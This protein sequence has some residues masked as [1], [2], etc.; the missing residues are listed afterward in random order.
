[1]SISNAFR[2]ILCL[3]LATAMSACSIL[4]KERVVATEG[5]NVRGLVL[6]GTRGQVISYRGI[7]YAAPPVDALR[8]RP[9]QPPEPWKGVLDATQYRKMCPQR[10]P[11]SAANANIPESGMSEDC[12][13][14]N[15]T[16]AADDPDEKRPV[17][18]WF[19]GGGLTSG[20]GNKETYN[21]APLPQKGV[22]LVS[23]THRLGPIGYMAHPE[24]SAESPHDASGN[25]GSLD[26]IAA[27]E[28]VQRNIAAFGGDPDNVTIFGVSGGGQ[29]VLF[30]LASPLA[31]GLFDRAVVMSGGIGGT[32]LEETEKL[33]VR[34]ANA[35]GVEND[36]DVLDALRA[37]S[38]QEI[39]E[40]AND[41]DTGYRS[42]FSIDGWSLH[43]VAATNDVPTIVGFMGA[44]KAPVRSP[45]FIARA[46]TPATRTL[47]KHY[48]YVFTHIP[49]EWGSRG[50]LAYHGGDVSYAFGVPEAI[51]DH[52]G[53][54]FRPGP[55]VDLPRDPGLDYR[56]EWVA[57]A[58]TDMF[59]Q[60]AKT[61]DPNLN[62]TQFE[63]LGKSW[64]WPQ[65][66]ERDLYLDIGIEP[67]VRK[68]W[69]RAGTDQQRPRYESP[70][71]T[72]A[73][74][75]KIVETTAGKV[76]GTV[77]ND[78]GVAIKRFKGIPYAAPP[79]GELRWKAP[80]GV[81]PWTGVRETTEWTDRC[82]Q[83]TSSMMGAGGMGFSEDCLYLN[84]VTPAGSVADN[85]PVMV[86]FHGGG[87]TSG[88]GNSDVYN[89][90]ALPR[91]GVVIVTVN[92]R[93][94]P[95]GYMA[96]P[97]LTAES[98]HQSSGNYGTLDL[99]ASLEWVQENIRAFGGN[100][101]NVLI[102]GESGGGT[103][104][105]SLLS[106]PLAEGLFHRAIIESGSA[107]SLP[108]R[109]TTL[110]E[111]EAAGKRLVAKLGLD[112][113]DDLLAALRAMKWEKIVAAA[114]DR[115][116]RF[117]AN[118]TV[119]GWILPV[120]VN[121]TLRQGRQHDVPLIVG[122]NQGEQR[123]L[124][125]DVPLVA[126]LWSKNVSSNAYV[127]NFSHV[128]TGWREDGCVAFHGLELPYV[129]G[130]IPD[131]LKVPTV[132]FLA[133]RTGCKDPDPG[134]DERDHV[135]ADNTMKMW[136]AFARTGDPGVEGLVTWPPYTKEDGS[137][138]DISYELA[139][140]RGIEDAYVAPPA[141]R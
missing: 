58:M 121:E 34:L 12:L 2:V 37:K 116:A 5:G 120:S 135:V 85:L 132:L 52:Y 38:W 117:S 94:G 77:V 45:A 99:I 44:E 87:L 39:I 124:Q 100:P 51:E 46:I 115:D 80:A 42:L 92:S 25:Y 72:P 111:A 103:K 50:A 69:V 91:K 17:M 43:G 56:D 107:S 1:M 49:Y 109:T 4:N 96:H 130:A 41:P 136:A 76:S 47:S 102:F 62:K 64:N 71:M 16:T 10:F 108:E 31:E 106:S 113:E 129:F 126:S 19:H 7:P 48:A 97:A 75:G 78:T 104:T 22:V 68:G 131:G 65:L 26:T 95:I 61:G 81:Q 112:D 90:T 53:I 89:N 9:P 8:W 67:M 21:S 57:R 101:D 55:G 139:V 127:Y 73:R 123:T 138:L 28:W 33:G 74:V 84:V 14:L 82:P 23:V 36:D 29:K 125:N 137:Y 141:A 105:L 134:A 88:T 11:A 6:D 110:E 79:L 27:L 18:V 24:L 118:L 32:P 93:L 70:E 114:S 40:A 133:A 20:W 54:Y 35:L 63:V 13:Y 98:G 66:D 60:F 140:K 119:D 3:A 122:A 86:F 83:P 30:L 128:P 15:V 59:V